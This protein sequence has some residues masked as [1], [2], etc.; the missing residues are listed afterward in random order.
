MQLAPQLPEAHAQLGWTPIFQNRHSA[1]LESFGHA[2]SIN[3]NFVDNR[4]ALALAYSGL[5]ERALE[6]IRASIHLDPFQP[7][8]SFAF[9]GHAHYLLGDYRNAANHLAHYPACAPVVRI[10]P[11]WL[12]AAQ[13]GDLSAARAEAAQVRRLEPEFAI[14]R[15]R[16]TAVYR[17]SEDAE[18]LLHGLRLAGLP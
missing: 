6:V 8:D 9:V 5:P 11:L 17:R 14:E 12:A 2:F 10:L 3:R 13:A 4:H 1:G 7:F 16:V 15:W 18:R